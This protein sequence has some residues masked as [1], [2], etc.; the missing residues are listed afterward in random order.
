M[1]RGVMRDRVEHWTLRAQELEAE[2][3]RITVLGML[4]AE[5]E[6][7]VVTPVGGHK[8]DDDEFTVNLEFQ[9]SKVVKARLRDRANAE[10][11]SIDYYVRNIVLNALGD[12]CKPKADEAVETMVH[13]EL[14]LS[15]L[16]KTRLQ[17]RASR[18]DTSVDSYVRLVVRAELMKR[19]PRDLLDKL[20]KVVPSEHYVH[21]ELV[22]VQP[23]VE[24]TYRAPEEAWRLVGDIIET[25]LHHAQ[26]DGDPWFETAFEIWTGVPFEGSIAQREICREREEA[27]LKRIG[28]WS[29]LWNWF[30]GRIW[31]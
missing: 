1:K 4:L 30:R 22:M 21:A 19:D 8:L 18:A 6:A 20:L 24:D 10:D 27:S 7:G 9:L 11:I 17:S 29:R 16:E 31:R 14:L 28:F 23:M 13:V 25:A 2:V 15:K 3:P 12:D 5:L 26:V